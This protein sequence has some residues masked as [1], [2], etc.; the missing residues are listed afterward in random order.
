MIQGGNEVGTFSSEEQCN[1]LT[2]LTAPKT[3]FNLDSTSSE[4]DI[5]N[6]HLTD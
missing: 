6:L 1:Q 4:S 5:C 3:Q 2:Q